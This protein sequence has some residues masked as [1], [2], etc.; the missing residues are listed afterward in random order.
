MSILEYSFF[1]NALLGC[2]MASILCGIVGTYIVSRRL[3]FISGGITHACFGGIGLGVYLGVNPILSAMLFA[4]ASACGVEW[5][6]TK[7]RIREDSAIALFWTLGMSIGIICCFLTPGFMPD[8]P[9]YLFGSVLTISRQDLILLFVVTSVVVIIFLSLGR[10]IVSVSFDPV[11]ARSRRL[12]VVWI[13][14]V[15]MIVIAVTIVS[16]LRLVGVVLAISLLTIPQMTA[17]L[18]TY[19]YMQMLLLSICFGV[20]Y[21]FFG[22]YFS[23]ILNVPSGASI[24]FVSIVG[25][26]LCRFFLM[27]G[28]FVQSSS[29]SAKPSSA[30]VKS[31][32]GLMV[33]L[34]LT[35]CGTKKNTASTRWWQSFNTRYNVYFNGS[36]AFIEGAQEKEQS[37]V[38]DYTEL[39]PLYPVS[40]KKNHDIGKAKFDVAILKSEKAIKL[41]SIKTRPQWNKSRRKTPSDI[42]WLSRREYNPFMWKAW[43]LMGKS[44]FQKGSFDEAA[45]TFSYMSRLYSTQPAINGIANAWLTRCYAEQGWLYEAEDII[46]KQRRDSI[47]YRAATDWDYALCDY[48]LHAGDHAQAAQYLRKVISHERRRRQRAR[49]WYLMGQL[50]TILG[51]RQAAYDAYRHVV[52]LNPPYQLSFNARIAQTEVMA[53]GA[54]RKMINKL[55]RMAASDNNKDYLDQV[56]YAIG[57][58][59]LANRDTV[60]AIAAYEKGCQKATRSGVE[61]G[62]L[63]LALGDVYWQRESYS[64]ARRCYGEAI[65]LLDKERDIYYQLSERSVVLD[66]LVPHTDA[67]H[68]QDSLQTLVAMSE[69]DR[70]AAID[71]VI[72]ELKR[73]EKEERRKQQELEAE[74][75]ANRQSAE[76][77]GNNVSTNRNQVKPNIPGTGEKGLWYF[78]N[79]MAVSQGKQMFQQQWGKRENVDDWQRVNKTVVRLDNLSTDNEGDDN[80]DGSASKDD[81]ARGEITPNDS[82]SSS[83]SSNVS[84]KDSLDPHTR[85]YYLAQLP[86]TPEDK[87]AS[88][89]LIMDGLYNSGVIFQDRLANMTLAL[90]QY[91]RLISQYP[92]YKRNDETLYHLYLLY[93]RQGDKVQADATLKRMQADYP[94]SQWTILLSDPYYFENQ[95]FGEHIEDSLYAA[96]YQAFRDDRYEEVMANEE[97]SNERFPLGA[98]RDKIV[99]ISGLSLL[100]QGDANA[101]LQRMKTVVEKYPTSEVSPIAGMIVKGVQEGRKIHGGK[102]DL[103]DVWSLRTEIA[104][105]SDSTLSDTLSVSRTVPHLFVILF[106]PSKVESNRLLFAVAKHNFTSFMVRQ[107]DIAIDE[108]EGIGRLVVSGFLNYDEAVQYARHIKGDNTLKRYLD[109]CRSIVVSET[110]L[111]LIGVKYSYDDYHQF[112]LRKIAPMKVSGEQLLNIPDQVVTEVSEEENDTNAADNDDDTEGDLFDEGPA[113]DDNV[114]IDFDDDFYR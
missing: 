70:N 51:N 42:E 102:F 95:R 76:S 59:H 66:E 48:Y 85:E 12:P 36:Q 75:Q 79:P 111:R 103:G 91:S 108:V 46:V 20:V 63:L 105:A 72:D 89:A 13:E 107:F 40:D 35:S 15:M 7:G 96:S 81:N 71:R 56:Y 5:A 93:L 110:N 67:I 1:Q 82:L 86:F 39:L 62:V 43:L 99:F 112:Y 106:E 31:L 17:N 14:Y 57:N 61:K 64:N 60:Q 16:T 29:S 100:N 88:D 113:A 25:Y 2:L 33:V 24:I 6:S 3:V 22:L 50:Q 58:I 38:D 74:E 28:H 37:S 78:Y 97:L 68:L 83:T 69:S 9:S 109:L 44:Q 114:D 101:C 84:E 26:L 19:N 92:D 104:L 90:K 98:H 11:F 10:M 23:Y 55:R 4:V 73:K 52:R 8:L 45:A 54:S 87:A 47:H 65:G 21:C 77:G 49:Q 30:V 53:A 80:N 41:H 32:T 94:E 27:M 18:F 34:T